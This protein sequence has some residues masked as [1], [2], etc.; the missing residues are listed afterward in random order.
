[1][2]TIV[3][4]TLTPALRQRLSQEDLG[5]RLG[6]ALPLITMDAAGR[7][8][9]ML[10]S[11]LEIRAYDAGSAGLVIQARSDSAVNLEWRDAATLVIVESDVVAYV[12]L[13]R[14]DGPLPVAED[15]RLAYFMLSVEEVRE[16]HPTEEEAGA[17]IMTGPRYEPPPDLNSAWARTTLAAVSQPRAR[18]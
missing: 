10:I 11:Y 16:D 7:P 15:E 1:V 3:G 18:A 17:R 6:A 8:H 9:P 14:L 5:A 2:S 4:K 13:R 12:K